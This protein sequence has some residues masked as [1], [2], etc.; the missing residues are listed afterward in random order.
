MSRLSRSA[1]SP[2]WG[3]RPGRE[4]P[5]SLQPRI[6][7]AHAAVVRYAIVLVGGL[8]TILITLQLFTIA[9]GQLARRRRLRH[10]AGRDRRAAEPLQLFAGLVLLF[11]RPVNVGDQV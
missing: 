1:C 6:G 11:A 4:S 7:T 3:R 2:G 5:R 8:A 9:V 10:R